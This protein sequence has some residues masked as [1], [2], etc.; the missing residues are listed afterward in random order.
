MRMPLIPKLR[1]RRLSTGKL[2]ARAIG[3]PKR[4]GTKS[5]RTNLN[6]LRRVVAGSS[7]LTSRRIKTPQNCSLGNRTMISRIRTMV[8]TNPRMRTMNDDQTPA[9]D[10]P[11]RGIPPMRTRRP[12]AAPGSPPSI[13]SLGSA[14]QRTSS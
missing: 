7:R 6:L 12:Q 8:T 13:P 14:G 4:C 9:A 10:H 11:R 5:R 3:P 2:G 1:K